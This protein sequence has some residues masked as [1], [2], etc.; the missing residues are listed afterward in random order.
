MILDWRKIAVIGISALLVYQS[1]MLIWASSLPAAIDNI[2]GD[3][4][5][6]LLFLY[7]TAGI[8]LGTMFFT[9]LFVRAEI[10][11]IIEEEY[12]YDEE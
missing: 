10:K 12:T 4:S 7:E 8:L 11:R 5:F 6:L 2:P 1:L 3:G 9:R